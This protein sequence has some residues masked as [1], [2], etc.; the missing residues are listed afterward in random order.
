MARACL[1]G[2]LAAGDPAA[3]EVLLVGE[4]LIPDA[5]APGAA[6]AAG[7]PG[8]L[9]VLEAELV[10]RARLLEA[11]DTPDFAS[12]RREHPDDPLPALVLVADGVS[13]EQAGRLAAILAQGARLGVGALLPGTAVDGG[14]QLVLD[15]TGRVQT[16][17][18]WELGVQQLV[19]ARACALTQAEAAELVGVLARSRTDDDVFDA[20]VEPS[21]RDRPPAA[22]EPAGAAPAAEPVA[23][24][25]PAGVAAADDPAGLSAEYGKAQAPVTVRLLGAM[26]ITTNA[27]ELRSG[28]RASARELLAYYLIH[29]D[30]ASLEQAVDA[31]W[32]DT[33]LGRER[34]R[35]W[36]ALGNLRTCCA[37]P[38]EPAT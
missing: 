22:E 35:F 7:L 18:P 37:R 26:Q 8:A 23:V 10:H 38:P 2:L 20:V 33:Q 13:L 4:R 29:P 9:Q 21:H 5:V 24:A 30:G 36:T 3:V 6:R 11:N 1:V 12:H 28:L 19:G 16:A 14:A 17:T 31:M 32:P 25:D 27:G 15:E 34:E